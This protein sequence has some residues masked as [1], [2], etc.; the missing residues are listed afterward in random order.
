M[1]VPPAKATP[2]FSKMMVLYASTDPQYKPNTLCELANVIV[3]PPEN[4]FPPTAR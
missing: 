4:S 3:V 2:L 1:K